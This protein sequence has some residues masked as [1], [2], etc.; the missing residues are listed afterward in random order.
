M[1][2]RPHS[3]SCPAPD[4]NKCKKYKCRSNDDLEGSWEFDSDVECAPVPEGC[5]AGVCNPETGECGYGPYPNGV[6][7]CE[8][9][10]SGVVQECCPGTVCQPPPNCPFCFTKYCYYPGSG[11]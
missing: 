4:G 3:A 2:M 6:R 8:G 5:A 1:I 11:N 9:S 7:H 10:P